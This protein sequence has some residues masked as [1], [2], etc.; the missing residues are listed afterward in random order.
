[1]VPP[2]SHKVSRASWY[3]G[4]RSILY[5]FRLQDCHPLWSIFPDGSASNIK[6]YTGPQPQ[7][8]TGLVWALSLSLA[9]TE[10]IEVSFFSSGYLDVS[11]PRV[12]LLIT[13][14]FS[15]GYSD[16]TLS[17]FPHSEIHGS[18]PAFGSPWL[19]ADCCVLLRLLVPRHSP[20][21][22]RSLIFLSCIWFFLAKS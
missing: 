22:L 15:D 16:I 7:S 5:R 21:A 4:F 10:E 9:A 19:F 12:C 1:M 13:Y 11:V 20:Y 17:G 3:S 14:G 2:A 18:K 8:I 6:S